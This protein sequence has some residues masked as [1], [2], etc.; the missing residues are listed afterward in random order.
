MADQKSR[1]GQKQGKQNAQ[2]PEQHL[3]T[4]TDMP[5]G[6]PD[7]DKQQDQR[8]TPDDAGRKPTDQTR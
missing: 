6:R 2:Q 8:S 5:H 1:G 4:K 7:K 3:G